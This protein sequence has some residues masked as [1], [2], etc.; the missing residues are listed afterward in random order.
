MKNL[1][2]KYWF[3]IDV[4][5]ILLLIVAFLI[6]KTVGGIFLIIWFF[7]FI[8]LMVFIYKEAKKRNKQEIKNI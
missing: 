3:L 7:A 1:I 2:I 6:N 5:L 8:G 4:I